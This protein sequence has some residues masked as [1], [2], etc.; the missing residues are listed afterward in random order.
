METFKDRQLRYA[1]IAGLNNSIQLAWKRTMDTQDTLGLENLDLK[2]TKPPRDYSKRRAHRR[3]GSPSNQQ[4]DGQSSPNPFSEQNVSF[5]ANGYP[6]AASSSSEPQV[7]PQTS[8]TS[9]PQ[10]GEN[11]DPNAYRSLSRVPRYQPGQGFVPINQPVQTNLPT[12]NS[13]STVNDRSGPGPIVKRYNISVF[14]YRGLP[15]SRNDKQYR[16]SKAQPS[17]QPEP[18]KVGRWTGSPPANIQESTAP[19]VVLRPH[20]SKDRNTRESSPRKRFARTPL[21][22]LTA[23]IPTPAYQAQAHATPT[24]LPSPQRL[25]LVLDLNGTL[26]YRAS[27]DQSGKTRDFTPRPSLS[28]FLQYAFANHSLLIWS[29]AQPYNVTGMCARLFEPTQ[30]K[31]LLGEWARDTLGLTPQQ[32]KERVQVYKRLDRIWDDERLQYRH[33]DLDQGGRWAQHNTLLIDDSFQKASAQPF[34][35]VEVPEYVEGDERDG[36]GRNVLAQVVGYLEEARRWNDVSAFVRE[37][38]FVVDAGWRWE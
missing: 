30:R 6:P 5:E 14:A 28:Q 9:S 20:K 26:L 38:G 33:P 4:N 17:V 24:L 31:L 21:T 19:P 18:G 15:A 7:P 34:N 29:S 2:K 8:Y 13:W 32:Y 27:R 35:H 23:P 11:F 37:H 10:W 16:Y 36:D 3:N 25:L 22:H 1:R 12:R